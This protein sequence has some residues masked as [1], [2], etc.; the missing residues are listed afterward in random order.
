[1]IL[2]WMAYSAVV[3]AVLL[4]GAAALARLLRTAGRPERFVWAGGL[5]GAVVIP[6]VQPLLR[7]GSTTPASPPGVGVLPLPGLPPV[8]PVD[9]AT[10]ALRLEPVLLTV[11]LG[12]SLVQL[13]RFLR[14]A[15]R[16]RQ[17]V[18]PG[19]VAPAVRPPPAGSRH[20][21]GPATPAEAAPLVWTREM[22]PAVSGFVRPRILLPLWFLEL[23]ARERNWILRHE[24]EHLRARDPLLH[25]VAVLV[26]I[27]LPW[28]PPALLLA[29]GL[30][31]AL[32]TDCDRRVLHGI[33]ASSSHAAPTRSY[34]EAL[35]RVAA[36]RTGPAPALGTFNPRITSLEHRIRTMTTARRRWTPLRAA[37]A[38]ALVPTALLVACDVPSPTAELNLEA[39]IGA[40]EYV[41]ETD[42]DSQETAG[43]GNPVFTP[44]TVRPEILNREEVVAALRTEY[45]QDLRD[46][47]LEGQ[48]NVW[49][50]ID[51]DGRVADT[52]IQQSSGH[53][54]LDR[55][56][57]RVAATME[58]S[59]ALNRD[60]PV[61]VW[62]A[63]PMTFQMQAA[64]DDGS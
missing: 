42:F 38:A 3:G 1:M 58:F 60:E 2:S 24:A 64:E 8:I 20:G 56:A 39:R 52:R 54:E 55:A 49:F 25:G 37:A 51:K 27:A 50:F 30:A 33:E 44:F 31:R 17:S 18:I 5:A 29:R 61:P 36:R 22:G 13:V 40:Q 12:L 62:V 16:I 34:G 28:N 53:A 10:S 43:A 21:R 7:A 35:L 26:R 48:T 4:S 32:E 6:L 45:R 23:P 15:A 63:F 46:A 47:G 14:A 57:L 9:A 11:W 19:A 41:A 59:P